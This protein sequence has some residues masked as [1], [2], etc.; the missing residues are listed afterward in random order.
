MLLIYIPSLLIILAAM[1]GMI[2]FTV[3]STAYGDSLLSKL[4]IISVACLLA[5]AAVVLIN[6][7][8][9]IRRLQLLVRAANGVAGGNLDV[10]IPPS[11]GDEVGEVASALKQVAAYLHRISDHAALAAD[12]DLTG[13]IAL[14]SDHDLPGKN[15]NR[16]MGNLKS[17]VHELK[18]EADQLQRASE[19]LAVSSAHTGNATSQIS[20]TIQQI[21]GGVS[22]STESISRTAA[23]IDEMSH[24]IDG[25]AKGAQ[26]QARA[27]NQA[28]SFTSQ[29]TEV[30]TRVNGNASVVV[31]EATRAAEVARKG[32]A[33]VEET[34]QGMEAIQVSVG[35]SAD[36]V[37]EMGA[38]TQQIESIIEAIDT[39]ASQTNLLA[40]N[41]AIEA[42]RAGAHGKGFAVVADE[43]RKLADRASNSTR[44]IAVIIQSI[45]ESVQE[46]VAA[47][48][49]GFQQVNTG[50]MQ[51][52]EAG[53]ALTEILSAVE[54]VTQRASGTLGATEK[55]R[56]LSDELSTAMESVSSVVEENTAATEEMSADS[57]LVSQAVENIAS[58]SQQNS[59]AVE[60]VGAT[61]E[62]LSSQ[63]ADVSRAVQELSRMAGVVSKLISHFQV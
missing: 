60:E 45:Q 37:K 29:L 10:D 49:N 50:V 3:N 19:N 9:F 32:S 52:H 20:T 44:E 61:A 24:A 46:A 41:A 48:D 57:S 25:I 14:E 6:S 26:E 15:F 8:M 54:A 36:K 1:V 62:E 35:L 59:A 30:I 5:F 43:V 7:L 63:A 23:S 42:A 58:I 51:A 12:G 38:R 13:Q 16:M 47:M 34:V 40:L 11:G 17:L 21:A 27:V 28:A 31:S 22:S 33:R 4:L 18:N 56:K 2:V 39:I 55:M 53:Q